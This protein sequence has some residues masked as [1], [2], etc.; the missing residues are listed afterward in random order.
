LQTSSIFRF[1]DPGF[2]AHQAVAQVAGAAMILLSDS[3]IIPF[4]LVRL[5]DFVRSQVSQTES[6]FGEEL[7]SQDIC[8]GQSNTQGDTLFSITDIVEYYKI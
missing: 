6:N 7:Q 4:S 5:S 2:L 1:L 8:L 3:L